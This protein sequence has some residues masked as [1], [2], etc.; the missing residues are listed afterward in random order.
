MVIVVINVVHG[1]VIEEIPMFP[2]TAVIPLAVVAKTVVNAAIE[3]NLR[4]P[5]T[6]IEEKSAVVPSPITRCPQITFFRR[7]NPRPR[8]PIIIGYA[9]VVGPIAGCPE[10]TISRA[11]GLLIDRQWGRADCD[12]YANLTEQDGWDGNR[13]KY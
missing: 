10:V 8:N 3:A 6:V 9:V 7:Q 2:A 13:K 5:I 11:K 1:T 12:P 4:P